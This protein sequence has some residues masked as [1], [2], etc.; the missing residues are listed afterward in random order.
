[1]RHFRYL[2][3][4]ILA[5]VLLTIGGTASTQSPSSEWQAWV[6]MR[7]SQRLMLFDQ[8]GEQF[9]FFRPVITGEPFDY[10]TNE[11]TLMAISR[12][13]H[14]LLFA[15]ELASGNQ[16]LGIYDLVEQRLIN[17]IEAEPN[18]AINLGWRGSNALTV[19]GSPL[20]F[21][22]DSQKAVVTFADYTLS[23]Q[24]RL[25]VID[26]PS[27]MVETQIAKYDLSVILTTGNKVLLNNVNFEPSNPPLYFPH[28]RPVYWDN[29]GGIHV[30]FNSSGPEISTKV[31]A[32]VWYPTENRAVE[33][34]Y[35][36]F[37][38]DIN[39][40]NGLVVMA[41]EKDH[42]IVMGTPNGDA[43]S[44][45]SLYRNN[46]LSY[47]ETYWLDSGQGVVFSTSGGLSGR[48]W[49]LF[50]PTVDTQSVQFLPLIYQNPFP[51]ADGVLAINDLTL[52]FIRG[53]ND[54]REIGN[55]PPQNGPA[56]ILWAQTLD[57]G[58]DNASN[59]ALPI[60]AENDIGIVDSPIVCIG[61]PPSINVIGT[62]AR[63][64]LAEGVL[65]NIRAE[66]FGTILAELAAGAT[67]TVISGSRCEG[68]YLWWWVELPNG[69]QGWA[70]EGDSNEYYFA[71]VP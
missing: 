17:S 19:A 51:V 58:L 62:E 12:D 61:A 46:D 7:G 70:A 60:T 25:L 4:S 52:T 13:G 54:T 64:T 23:G 20:I 59:C 41:S 36:Y 1:M 39:G 48:Q 63:V 67:F 21:S 27:G 8:N 71:P 47:D 10:P 69:R 34:P 6:L 38:A 5:L 33:S 42:G 31:P 15:T 49:A 24:W 55:V 18:E 66:P 65:M 44:I 26:L 53:A 2:M 37:G 32:F 14:Y 45:E 3:M 16:A 56:V 29:D 57:C 11:G 30:Q 28:P 50:N 9:Q 22:P 40:K 43:M 68:G 35:T